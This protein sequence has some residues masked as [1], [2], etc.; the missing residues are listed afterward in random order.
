MLTTHSSMHCRQAERRAEPSGALTSS[1]IE[2]MRVEYV[3]MP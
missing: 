2:L 3:E 1:A